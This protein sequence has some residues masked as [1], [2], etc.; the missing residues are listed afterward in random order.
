MY[1][2]VYTNIMISPNIIRVSISEAARLFGVNPQT[3]RRAIKGKEVTYVIVRGRYKLNFESVLKWSQK[4]ASARNKL[5]TNGIGRFVSSWRISNT[6]YSPNP[7]RHPTG[8][9]VE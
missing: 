9:P 6:L 2:I 7:P 3:I 1:T 5:G 4:H 8:R